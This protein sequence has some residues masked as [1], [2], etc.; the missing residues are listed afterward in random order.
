MNEARDSPN[1]PIFD[2]WQVTYY[3]MKLHVLIC[4]MVLSELKILCSVVSD[5]IICP[6]S[7]S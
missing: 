5:S 2:D 3:E 4:N 7:G 6:G 1:T